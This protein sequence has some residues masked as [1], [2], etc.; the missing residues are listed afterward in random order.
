M[1]AEFAVSTAVALPGGPPVSVVMP[2]HNNVR[3]VG[4]AVRSVINQQFANFEILIGDDGSSDG[5]SEIIADLAR[6]DSRIR[7]LRRLRPSGAADAINWVVAEARHEII[8]LTHADDISYP[9]RLARQVSIMASAL[10]IVLV[11]SPADGLDTT[12]RI[13]HPPHLLRII[14][15]HGM[16]PFAHSSI[17]FRRDAF[18]TAGGYRPAANYWEDLD[19]YWRMAAIGRVFVTPCALTGYRYSRD[20]IRSRDDEED[21]ERAIQR[22]YERAAAVAREGPSAAAV[23]PPSSLSEKLRPRV[24]VARAWVDVWNG[25]RSRVIRRLLRQARLRA[26]WETVE[27]LVF[28]GWASVSPRSLRWALRRAVGVTNAF[29]AR[30]LDPATPVE[31]RPF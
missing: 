7:V 10:D 12:G 22:M 20:S 21:V 11:G 19:L 18:V 30:R 17:T 27:A 14:R 1:R 25:C 29:A 31:W 28:L 9:D 13:V 8:A 6:A 26:D 23:A 15:P 3:F 5:S 24:F 16:A 4:D 2:V